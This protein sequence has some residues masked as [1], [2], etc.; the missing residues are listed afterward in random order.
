MRETES[1]GWFIGIPPA[2]AATN[3][4]PIPASRYDIESTASPGRHQLRIPQARPPPGVVMVAIEREDPDDGIDVVL[5]DFRGLLK[6][7]HDHSH[8][9]GAHSHVHQGSL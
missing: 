5:S 4:Y 3:G 7:Y 1:D 8:E 2:R 6:H 9:P